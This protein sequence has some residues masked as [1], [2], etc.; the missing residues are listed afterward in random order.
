[1]SHDVQSCGA[2]APLGLA[3]ERGN[4]DRTVPL[5]LTQS[6]R[7]RVQSVVHQRAGRLE[8]QAVT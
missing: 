6:S 3:A 1:M 2:P 4:A 8:T 5:A 7:E